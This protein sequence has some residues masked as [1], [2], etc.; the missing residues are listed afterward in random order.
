MIMGSAKQSIS[1]SEPRTVST[2]IV[3]ELII[4]ETEQAG[5]RLWQHIIAKPDRLVIE[6]EELINEP[7]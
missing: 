6:P 7:K 5:D 2:V 3:L 4:S 1:D